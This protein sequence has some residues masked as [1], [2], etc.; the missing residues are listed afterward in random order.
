MFS[1][2]CFQENIVFAHKIFS[3]KYKPLTPRILPGLLKSE[4]LYGRN[5]YGTSNNLDEI[6]EKINRK[7][8]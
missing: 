1:L 2:I 3:Y 7:Y 6:N 5:A 8:N 4:I